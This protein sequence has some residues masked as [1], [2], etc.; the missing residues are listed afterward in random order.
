VAVLVKY[1]CLIYIYYSNGVG[2]VVSQEGFLLTCQAR[3]MTTKSLA[4][5][6]SSLRALSQFHSHSHSLYL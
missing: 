3:A 4:L 1:L 2:E 6:H 5:S